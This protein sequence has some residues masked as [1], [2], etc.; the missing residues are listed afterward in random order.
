MA[1]LHAFTSTGLVNGTTYFFVVS[2]VNDAG[3]SA[4]SSQVSATPQGQTTPPPG[5][6]GVTVTPVAAASGPWFNEQQL[7]IANTAPITALSVTI[8]LQRTG[9]ISF[10]GQYN[11]V[12]GQIA[13]SNSSTATTVTYQFTLGAG[14]T[15]GPATNRLFAAQSSGTGTVHPMAGDTFTV[16]YTTG[17]QN[18]TQTNHF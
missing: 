17:G 12:G 3:Q 11:T 15:L 14:Q 18:F 9:G 5:T 13:Q 6:G 2:A 10:S 1:P 16:T 4:N 7:R 8:V